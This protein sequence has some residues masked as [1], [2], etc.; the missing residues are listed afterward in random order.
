MSPDNRDKGE[1][2]LC[3]VSDAGRCRASTC[4]MPKIA[5]ALN[6]I[7]P[8][9]FAGFEANAFNLSPAE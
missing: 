8:L 1:S 9:G 7:Q 3:L 6:S 5:V 2:P 4:C